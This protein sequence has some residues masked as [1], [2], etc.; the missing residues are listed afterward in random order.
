MPSLAVALAPELGVEFRDQAPALVESIAAYLAYFLAEPP[1]ASFDAQ[2]LRIGAERRRRPAGA[3][4]VASRDG[5]E[6]RAHEALLFFELPGVEAWCDPA[7]G[8]AGIALDSEEA[9][10]LDRVVT[11]LL[12]PLLFE[13]AGARG[14]LGLHAAAVAREGHGILLPGASGCGKST[15][16][17]ACRAAG[18]ALL[19]D[20]LVWL[21]PD[22]TGGL[23]LRPFPRGAPYPPPP[24]PTIRELAPV[25][26]VFPEH[27]GSPPSRLH[28][29]ASDESLRRLAEQ[30]A[31]LAPGAARGERF[32][33][34]VRASRLPAY[35]LGM[36]E[37]DRAGAPALL[38]ELAGV[39]R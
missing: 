30:A 17:A 27:G 6:V 8:M 12:A 21:A 37:G 19:S 25:L 36:A 38:A 26:V 23:C 15:I 32:R 35:V 24:A 28:P 39:E 7:R 34:L 2:P 22:R 5:L 16:F 11:Q 13:L 14:W 3:K 9:G 18:F 31:L 1:G 29:I 33:L 10:A 4:L 20:D